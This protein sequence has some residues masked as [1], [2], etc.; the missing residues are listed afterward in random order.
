[1]GTSQSSK[2][3]GANV[4]LVP[5]WA[6]DL[7]PEDVAPPPADA[8]G[9]GDGDGATQPGPASSDLSPPNRF[10]SARRQLGLFMQGGGSAYL[11][12]GV[13]RY[14]ATGYGGSRTMA[15]RMSSTSTTAARLSSALDPNG[16]NPALDRAILTGRSVDEVLDALVEAVQPHDGTQ[17]AEASRESIRQAMADLLDEHPSVDLFGLSDEEREFVVERYAANDVCRRFELD[18]GRQMVAKAP[19]PTVALK[20]MQEAKDYIGAVVAQ[21]FADL[22][23]RGQRA[24]AEKVRATVNAAFEEAFSVFEGHIK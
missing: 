13:G 17:D 18:M 12:S 8:D 6:D 23:A 5:P 24:T 10:G 21:A 19:N 20:R 11:R 2:G 1:M 16:A 3:P 22:A 4:P 15:R 9:D 7:P 14:V